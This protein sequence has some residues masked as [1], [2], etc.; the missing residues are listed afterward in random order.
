[1]YIHIIQTMSTQTATKTTWAID[2]AHS[3]IGFKVRHMMISSV[4]GHF[5]RFTAN[6]AMDDDD[7]SSAEIEV[8]VE[9][10][11]VNT[12]NSDR[13]NHLRSDD[14]FNA[15]AFP[16]IHFQSK[17]F[18]GS[19]LIGDLT[20]RDITA[21]IELDV[22]YNGTARDPYGQTKSGFEI[23]GE[24]S[25]KAYGLK[26]N[27]VTEAGSVVVSDKVQLVIAAQFIKQA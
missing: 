24:I 25:R 18:D 9:T 20:I 3:E 11:S 13:D 21:E 5:D 8:S 19:K 17:S 10:A 23:S 7:F 1:M 12:K 6:V 14:F 22:E 15:E 26:W 16:T 4:T 2:T 27:A